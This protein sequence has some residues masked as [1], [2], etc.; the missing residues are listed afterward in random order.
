V[1]KQK[2]VY[3]YATKEIR[4]SVC[5][6]DDGFMEEYRIMGEDYCKEIFNKKTPP[7][8]VTNYLYSS[9]GMSPKEI[10]KVWWMVRKP[11]LIKNFKTLNWL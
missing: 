10:K 6:V 4:D 9:F 5:I 8:S 1:N 3:D 11:V 2:R 7:R